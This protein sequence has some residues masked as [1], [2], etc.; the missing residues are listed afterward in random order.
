MMGDSIIMPIDISTAATTKSM[1]KKGTNSKKPIWN[2]VLSS[3][4]KNEGSNTNNGTS[5]RE[6][7][8]P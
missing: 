1:T 4:V 7:K 8:A 2:A 3:L 5:S 6:A